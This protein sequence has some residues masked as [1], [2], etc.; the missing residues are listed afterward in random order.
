M[1]R[2]AQLWRNRIIHSFH[3][4]LGLPVLI[5]KKSQG[6]IKNLV[7]TKTDSTHMNLV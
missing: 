2:F 4:E 3:S 7:H 1:S 5:P 6:E